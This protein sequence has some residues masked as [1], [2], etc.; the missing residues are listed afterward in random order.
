MLDSSSV[1]GEYRKSRYFR[2]YFDNVGGTGGT[3]FAFHQGQ[4]EQNTK[5]TKVWQ[6]TT[7]PSVTDKASQGC[8]RRSL[9]S[10]MMTADKL[11]AR[12]PPKLILLS[13]QPPA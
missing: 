1:E 13:L 3:A 6:E 8:T 5:R 2:M 12:I 4:G 11:N 9:G 10:Y 7:S